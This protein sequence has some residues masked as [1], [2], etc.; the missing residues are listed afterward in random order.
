MVV[1]TRGAR[2]V[3]G[4]GCRTA[5]AVELPHPVNPTTTAVTTSATTEPRVRVAAGCAADR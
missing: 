5:P 3:V 4:E 1:A 2:V